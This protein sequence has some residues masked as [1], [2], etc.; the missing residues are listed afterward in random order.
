M[1]MQ[2]GFV[3]TFI[4][5]DVVERPFVGTSAQKDMM[6]HERELREEVAARDLAYPGSAERS[7]LP[8]RFYYSHGNDFVDQS[9]FYSTL[10]HVTYD[11]AAVIEA[12]EACSRT[13]VLWTYAAVTVWMNGEKV[14]AIDEP[15]YKP[16][17]KR[18]FTVLLPAGENELYVRLQTLGVRDT[19]SLFGIE[20]ID[21]QGLGWTVP[22]IA[23][24]QAYMQAIDFLDAVSLVDNQLHFPYGR[25]DLELGWD[26]Q[27]PDYSRVAFRYQW[28]HLGAVDSYR[29]DGNR[30]HFLVRVG[31]GAQKLQRRFEAIEQIRP[32]YSTFPDRSSNYR[33]MLTQIARAEGLS[34]GDKFGFYIQN[35]LARKALGIEGERDDEHLMT[36]LQQIDDRY[37]CSDF[38]VSG[39]IRYLRSYEVDAHVRQ[40]IE[41][42]LFNWRYWMSMEGSDGMCFWSENHSLLFYSSAMIV[43]SMYPDAYFPTAKMS[44]RE[45]EAFGER[46]T[47]E[48]LADVE[49]YGYEE[50]LSTVYMNVTF[51]SLLNIIDYA[52][53]AISVRARAVTDLMLRQLSMHTFDGAIIAPMGR[54]YRSVIT[55]TKQGAQALMNLVNPKVPFSYGEG[56]LSYFATSTYPIPE[57]LTALMDDP[58]E[59]TYSTGNALVAITKGEHYILTS[60][61]SPRRDGFVRWENVTLTETGDRDR[62]NHLYTKS[63]NERFH[64]TTLFASGVYGYQQHLWSAALSNEAIVFVNHPG[65]TSDSSSMRPGY[66]FGNGI[67]PALRQEGRVLAAIYEISDDHPIHFTHLFL[68]KVKFDEVRRSGQ[69]IFARK[70]DGYL[71]LWCSRELVAYD[72]ELADCEYRAW[73]SQT[74]YLCVVGSIDED[75][76]WTEFMQG[77]LD[78]KI[79]YDTGQRS[80]HL[81]GE[82]LLTYEDSDDRTQYV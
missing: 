45:L 47:A 71:A 25:D 12:E 58:V 1:Y 21:T 40:R 19:R 48:W 33:R 55:P 72:D 67:M 26:E 5:S 73:G 34:R 20:V 9:T 15:A 3:N 36:T 29:L 77:R 30:P 65:G 80:L 50:F 74:A 27:S 49:E 53:E 24:R 51:A 66:W 79:V 41:H 43:G 75:S 16:I 17:M 7:P 35:I 44:G 52:D 46:L 6:L 82:L 14:C 10:T 2:N 32:E 70:G 4:I 68:P 69:W 11:A 78:S 64:G 22:A 61:Q 56:W 63:F 76:S 8:W 59:T 42:S 54:V 81:D 31:V 38:L 28:E 62:Q 39:V 60:V 37:D 23:G 57:G 18:S 13:L